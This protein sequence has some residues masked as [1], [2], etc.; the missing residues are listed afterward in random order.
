MRL[1]PGLGKVFARRAP[2]FP[3][4][5]RKMMASCALFHADPGLPER[6]S[7]LS[8]FVILLVAPGLLLPM[9]SGKSLDRVC[10]QVASRSGSAS[11]PTG[12]RAPELSLVRREQARA[13]GA[14]GRAV[15][16]PIG[17]GFWGAGGE[18]L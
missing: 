11:G 9:P 1:V 5:S 10:A 8:C 16:A 17:W 3:L 12:P 6:R 14:P 18:D 13:G 4:V 7:S 15:R 2:R